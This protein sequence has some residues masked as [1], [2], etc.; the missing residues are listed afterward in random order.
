M[1]ADI[2]MDPWVRLMACDYMCRRQ[3]HLALEKP[4]LGKQKKKCEKK[5]QKKKKKKKKKPAWLSW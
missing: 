4:P 5:K 2:A 3:L 1:A